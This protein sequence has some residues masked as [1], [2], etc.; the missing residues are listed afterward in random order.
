M[1]HGRKGGRASRGEFGAT[2]GLLALALALPLGLMIF[3][4][5]LM[6]ERGWEQFLGTGL[7][8][9]ATFTLAY[10]LW[11]LRREE[12]AF[13]EAPAWLDQSQ[14]IN[15]ADD[16]TLAARLRQIS[17][18]SDPAQRASLSQLME[19]NAEA[20][21][22]D[23]EQSEGRFVLTR[24]VLYLL[25]VIGF[26]G[27]V[28][29]ISK[30][31]MEISRVLPMVKELDGFLNN[32]TSVT[33][34]LQK[35]FDSTLLAL[36]LSASLMLIQTMVH[37]RAEKFL[38]LVDR[39]V[40]E[41]WLPRLAGSASGPVDIAEFAVQTTAALE[42]LAARMGDGLGP[43]V[44]RFAQ[45]VAAIDRGANTIA[46]AGEDLAGLATLVDELD[47]MARRG[48]SAL[49]RI[50]T[51]LTAPAEP[52][53]Q[54]ELIRRAIERSCAATEALGTHWTATYEKSSRAS[55]EQLARTLG[56]LKEALELLQVSIEQ[57][58]A[59][60]RNIVKKML[61]ATAYPVVAPTDEQ[62]A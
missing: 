36:F 1:S 34:A 3:N 59:L 39:W 49:A 14:T 55:Q 35:A 28:E 13:L 15:P 40:V 21:S 11:G 7:Y 48:L 61:P 19:V 10:V 42:A 30:A 56:S 12:R 45:A 26:I 8:F 2:L 9:F 38:A 60:Y 54:L 47:D 17:Q 58:N 50:E 22:L 27:T 43:H 31:L 25:P 46:R 32:L 44:D 51:A 52:D 16:R 37:R 18:T 62:A 4:P 29:G 57:G 5:T 24:Y 41:N 53:P 23:Q 33:A 20:S 6:F